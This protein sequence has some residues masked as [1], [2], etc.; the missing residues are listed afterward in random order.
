M[1][2]FDS[3]SFF[4]FA[5][6]QA[7]FKAITIWLGGISL[8]TFVL[9]LVLL[10]YLIRKIPS[11]YF[12]QL[13]DEQ[14]RFKEYDLKFVLFFLLRNIFGLLLFISG[15]VMLFLP[16]QGLITLFFSL[17]FLTF[18]GKKKLIIYFTRLK[19]VQKTVNWVRKKANKNPIKWPPK[20]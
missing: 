10:P 16:G 18:P 2:I 5:D 3:L 14:P 11:D 20:K 1:D 8:L 15:I 4:S 9:S 17:L 12:L 19:S 7:H 6:A 13:S